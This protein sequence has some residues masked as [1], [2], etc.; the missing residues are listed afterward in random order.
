MKRV[1]VLALLLAFVPLAWA[2]EV[3]TEPDT[4]V[5]A[6]TVDGSQQVS[7]DENSAADAGASVESVEAAPPEVSAA[8]PVPVE[9]GETSASSH[10]VVKGDTLWDLAGAYLKDPFLW[11]KIFE[12]NREKIEIPQLI[13]PNQVFVIPTLEAAAVLAAVPPPPA[14]EPAAE[15][16]APAVVA[17]AEPEVE[18][19][20]VS[21]APAQ[22]ED[23]DAQAAAPKKMIETAETA[24]AEASEEIDEKSLD[25]R[26]AKKKKTMAVP[27]A[28][29]MGGMADSFLADETWEYDG[30]VLRDRD[31]RMMISQGDVVF[32]NI[33]AASGV[34]P[35]MVAH[36]YRVGKKVKDPYLKKKAGRM[37]K[38]VGSVIVTGQVTDE[39]CTAVVTNSLEPLRIGDIVKFVA[40]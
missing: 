9:G 18:P 28:G 30:Y 12:A 21:T 7:A 16:P 39:G 37:V 19:E 26:E 20:S 17:E 35:K 2:E 33:G 5:P 10:K 6:E 3:P 29:F 36:V 25:E 40:R 31:Q 13:F 15:N 34:K 32:L 4:V 8:V 14:A 27:G 24:V 38:R 11:P 23:M 1:I 22:A